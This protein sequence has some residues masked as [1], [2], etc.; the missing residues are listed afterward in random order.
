MR[1]PEQ[2]NQ[3]ELEAAARNQ[4]AI[5]NS[6]AKIGVDIGPVVE[7]SPPPRVLE[8][9]QKNSRIIVHALGY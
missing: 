7:T 5:R 3:G 6:D 9:S 1:P 8:V 2:D 4:K